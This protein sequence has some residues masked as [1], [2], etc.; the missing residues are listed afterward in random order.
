[1]EASI[2][3]VKVARDSEEPYSL[4]EFDQFFTKYFS[5]DL[6]HFIKLYVNTA[7]KHGCDRST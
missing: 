6:R 7:V 1:M 4:K 5:E 3:T 2:L